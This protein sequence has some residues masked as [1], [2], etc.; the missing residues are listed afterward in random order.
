MSA[1][2]RPPFN[3]LPM[4]AVGTGA[5]VAALIMLPSLFTTD[6]QIPIPV[7]LFA[8]AGFGLITGFIELP[9]WLPYRKRTT[10]EQR[11]KEKEE[12][13]FLKSQAENSNLIK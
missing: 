1:P 12:Y 3:P 8:M 6:E 7:I 5:L 10:P 11:K 13:L 4:L 9:K 2:K